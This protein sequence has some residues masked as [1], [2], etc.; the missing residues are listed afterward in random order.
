MGEKVGAK[1][2]Y[3]GKTAN[4]PKGAATLAEWLN[5]KDD[6]LCGRTPRL[7]GD[8]PQTLAA[9]KVALAKRT[10]PKDDA[11]GELVSSQCSAS[12][13]AKIPAAPVP[14]DM[15]SAIA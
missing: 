12:R 15:N 1:F 11:D 14:S 2:W 10:E 6:L 4:D 3:F 5:Q 8:G 9:L 13:G 7:T